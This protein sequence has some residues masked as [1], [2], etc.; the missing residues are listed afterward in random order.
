VAPGTRLRW[1]IRGLRAGLGIAAALLA[2]CLAALPAFA[3]ATVTAARVGLH[4][5]RTRF[6]LDLSEA[7]DYRIFTLSGPDRIVVEMGAVEWRV[8][9]AEK[10]RERGLIRAYRF[11]PFG[12]NHSR[13]VLDLAGP[14]RVRTAF[15]MPPADGNPARLVLDLEPQDAAAFQAG[16]GWPEERVSVPVPVRKPAA[17]EAEPVSRLGGNLTD[18]RFVV[19]I[20]PGHGGIDPGAT[21]VSGVHEKEIALA[22]GLE[23]RKL[24]RK[25]GYEVVMTR[26]D[27][28][29]LKLK[30]RVRVAREAQSDLFISI[31]ADS[32]GRPGVR[33]ASVYTLS[34]TASD[35][36]AEALAAAENEA[37]V[38]AGVDLSSEPDDVSGILID[39]AQRETKNRSVSF[40]QGLLPHLGRQT[41]LLPETHRFAG[42]RVLK[43][44]DVPSVL[45]ELGF[46]SN[47]E[48]E[49]DLMSASWQRKIAASIAAAVTEYRDRKAIVARR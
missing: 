23:L 41:R 48:D 8:S 28:T 17:E 42:F 39:L 11:G 46:L 15:I 9:R 45:I 20:D 18:D 3:Q 35:K 36:E 31:H 16:A 12:A 6:V 40:A 37:D 30:E 7:V 1:N 47:S 22:V 29:F 5:D 33:G 27:D 13:A 25:K 24:L 34:E 14:A 44:P 19:T 43:A 32:I 49:G 21:G 4:E 2:S 38:I 10:V 26:S